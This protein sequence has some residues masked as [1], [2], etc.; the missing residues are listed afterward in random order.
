ML[1]GM[2]LPATGM[3]I[4]LADGAPQDKHPFGKLLPPTFTAAK[5]PR[6]HARNSS[7][8]FAKTARLS[9]IYNKENLKRLLILIPGEIVKH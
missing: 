5:I 3:D 9:I 4:C 2:R 8:C 7:G 1:C 6:T